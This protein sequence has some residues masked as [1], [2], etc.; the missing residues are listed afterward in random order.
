MS[1]DS[2]FSKKDPVQIALNHFRAQFG[3]DEII[4]LVYRP[5]DGDLFSEASLSAIEGIRNDILNFRENL[6]QDEVSALE[7][8]TKVDTIASARVLKAEDEF[9]LSKKFIGKNFPNNEAEKEALQTEAKKQKNFPLFYF[10]NDFQYGTICLQTDMGAIPA[11]QI[12]GSDEFD[13][14]EEDEFGYSKEETLMEIDE[15]IQI[16]EV[17]FKVTEMDEYADLMDAVD[18]IIHQ[19]KYADQLEYYPVG[20]PP[21]MQFFVD[22]IKEM[23]PLFGGML[24]IMTVLLWFLFRFLSAVVWPVLIV[25]LSCICVVG[26]S[27]WA[28][29]NA[30]INTA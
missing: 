28:I 8:I 21:M 30:L 7:H 6:K 12:T 4:C 22:Q 13:I 29:L 25:I 24:L 14:E 18:K 19:P 11:N 23:G 5:K 20:T 1:L 3:S 17:E 10:S 9:L 27:G 26:L 2:W 16:R 15:E